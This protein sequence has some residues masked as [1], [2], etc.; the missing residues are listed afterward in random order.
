M[1]VQN[2]CSG[3]KAFVDEVLDEKINSSF[4]LTVSIN[5]SGN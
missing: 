2:D 4:F 5:P 3:T 1:E